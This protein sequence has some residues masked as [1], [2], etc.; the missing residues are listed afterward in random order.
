[1]FVYGTHPEKWRSVLKGTVPVQSEVCA[2]GKIALQASFD[3]RCDY[4]MTEVMPL[5]IHLSSTS[6]R[7]VERTDFR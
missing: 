2:R 1:V 6:P 7:S 5:R 4:Y 3:S